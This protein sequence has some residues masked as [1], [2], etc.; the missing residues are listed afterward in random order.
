MTYK[1][2]Y[3]QVNANEMQAE[4]SRV[5]ITITLF[6]ND[7]SS[8]GWLLPKAP[9][10]IKKMIFC[11]FAGWDVSSSRR[12]VAVAWL[13]PSN[14]IPWPLS[15]SLCYFFVALRDLLPLHDFFYSLALSFS[16]FC[17]VRTLPLRQILPFLSP[18]KLW[19]RIKGP[20][21]TFQ[22]TEVGAIKRLHHQNPDS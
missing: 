2:K 13:L 10:L 1:P 7:K 22:S 3:N 8:R 15:W 16:D 12:F 20:N 6:A 5:V 11:M 21:Y 19:W 18:G 4:T 9:Q 17:G 14:G